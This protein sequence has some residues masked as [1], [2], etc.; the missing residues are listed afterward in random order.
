[1]KKNLLIS[2]FLLLLTF[3]SISQENDNVE[4][5]LLFLKIQELEVEIANL[6]NILESQDYLIQKLIKESVQE[7]DSTS[8]GSDNLDDMNSSNSIRFIGVDD[9]QSKEEVYKK[10]INALGDQD[11]V[12]A[13]SLFSYF[14][15][16]FT[17]DEK[18]PLSFFFGLEKLHSFKKTINQ[19]INIS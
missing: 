13:S 17:D 9:L 12:K 2:S 16:S 6:R 8:F 5:D 19:Q 4:V 14:V 15:E 10:A 7:V 1:M 18:L 11:F 3:D